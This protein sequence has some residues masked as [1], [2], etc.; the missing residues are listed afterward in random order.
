MAISELDRRAS[1][2][3]DSMDGLKRQKAAE[4]HQA[5]RESNSER[6]KWE[7]F[8]RNHGPESID[9]T[10]DSIEKCPDE[11]EDIKAGIACREMLQKV[12]AKYKGHVVAMRQWT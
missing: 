5:W 6:L 12:L 4:E 2:L 7:M 1:K 8:L 10:E 11:K 9:W 3:E